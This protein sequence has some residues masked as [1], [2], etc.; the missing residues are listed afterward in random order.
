MKPTT[1]TL[2]H[3]E[4][5]A[6]LKQLAESP[7]P[8]VRMQ[9]A[10]K[11]DEHGFPNAAAG[12]RWAARYGKSPMIPSL[13]DLSGGWKKQGVIPNSETAKH[14]LPNQF[15]ESYPSLKNLSTDNDNTMFPA[16]HGFLHSSNGVSFGDDGEPLPIII[17]RNV[18]IRDPRNAKLGF[19]K[20]PFS[21]KA[22]S[23]TSTTIPGPKLPVT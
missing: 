22:G 11:L 2:E 18:N 14:E 20:K 8:L 7:D 9:F 6:F 10:D 1:T 21:E 3:P 13:N 5:I 19:G 12:Q 15:H 23:F 16:E 4:H 17:S